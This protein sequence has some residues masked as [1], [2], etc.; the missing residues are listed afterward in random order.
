[1]NRELRR[2][3]K[4]TKSSEKKQSKAIHHWVNHPNLDKWIVDKKRLPKSQT[5]IRFFDFY[6]SS[7][8]I[9]QEKENN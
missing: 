9:K 4:A 2:A 7:T 8:T 3:S 6:G 5:S 1:M